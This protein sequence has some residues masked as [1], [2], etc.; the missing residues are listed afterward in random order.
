M[1]C[2][3]NSFS[4]IIHCYFL[5]HCYFQCW[6]LSPVERDPYVAPTSSE[7]AKNSPSGDDNS[8]PITTDKTFHNLSNDDPDKESGIYFILYNLDIIDET[9]HNIGFKMSHLYKERNQRRRR[10]RNISWDKSK[11]HSVILLISCW[12]TVCVYERVCMCV[13][14]LP[15][16]LFP[17]WWWW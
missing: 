11:S 10:R 1:I 4:I 9:E 15:W 14:A 8:N 16:L 13:C 5:L 3:F 12:R 6:K 2:W 7:V 17:R